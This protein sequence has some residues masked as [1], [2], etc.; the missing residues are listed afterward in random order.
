M[1]LNTPISSGSSYDETC[2]WLGCT[3]AKGK[4]T[5][6][7]VFDAIW[8]EFQTITITTRDNRLL[9]YWGNGEF[10]G[11]YNTTNALLENGDGRCSAWA[12]FFFNTIRFQGISGIYKYII[13]FNSVYKDVGNVRYTFLA[14]KQLGNIFQGRLTTSSEYMHNELFANHM[15]IFG[16]SGSGKSCGVARIIQNILQQVFIIQMLRD[17]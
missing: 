13:N 5:E 15:C 11:D 10:T 2:V 3:A 16:N 6:Q 8:N 17:W 12:D 7:D 4:S 9:S 14:L 1:T